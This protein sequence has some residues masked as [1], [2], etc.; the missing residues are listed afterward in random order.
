[1]PAEVYADLV[2]RQ[3]CRAEERA[4]FLRLAQERSPAARDAL[5]ERFMPL[6]RQMARRYQAVAELEDLDRSRRSAC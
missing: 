3:T 2:Q 6:A 4:L 5:M 1:M